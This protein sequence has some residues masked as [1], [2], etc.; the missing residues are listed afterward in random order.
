MENNNKL[1][2]NKTLNIAIAI[3]LI[4]LVILFFFLY[5]Q[6]HECLVDPFGYGNKQLEKAGLYPIYIPLEY[7][8]YEE[9][10][11]LL[12]ETEETTYGIMDFSEE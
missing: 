2:S 3:V 1:L 7:L 10:I 6:S 5:F 8:S 4:L 9:R 11:K 12:E